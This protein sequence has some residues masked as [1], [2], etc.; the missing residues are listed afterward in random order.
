MEPLTSEVRETVA[1]A[2]TRGGLVVALTGA[3]ISAESGIP[4]FRGPEGW[5]TV[6]SVRYTPQEIATRATFGHAPGAVWAWYLHRLATV[7]VAAPNAAH[8]ALVDIER[9]LG[10]RFV[11]VTQNV[12]GLHRR[13]G[14]TRMYEIHGSLEFVRCADA[15]TSELRPLP[16]LLAD[17]PPTDGLT[18]AQ[19]S[20]LTCPSCGGWL[21]P[22]VLWF[23]EVYD[24]EHFRF[25][26]TIAAAERA[27][28]LVIIGT[29]GATTLPALMAR[30]AAGAGATLVDINPEDNP[31]G[32]AARETGGAVVRSPAS[33]VLPGLVAA[34][35]GAGQP[36]DPG[37]SS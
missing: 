10:D 29:S 30:A 3:G 1:G 34:I 7:R 13:A 15:C 27:T 16:E 20:A 2:A 32:D 18:D 22:H 9:A 17:G 24:E 28:L 23:D 35:T 37:A 11:L 25:D 31:F 33:E 6:G 21:R 5:W 4:T 36:P 26:S 8:H 14:S 12:D 19:R